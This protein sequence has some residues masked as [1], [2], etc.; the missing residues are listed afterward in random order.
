MKQIILTKASAPLVTKSDLLD[1]LEQ[2][3]K[4]PHSVLVE[5][6]PFDPILQYLIAPVLRHY[7]M[8]AYPLTRQRD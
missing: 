8:Y 6:Y 7:H 3:S 4:I 1:D 2:A 5:A